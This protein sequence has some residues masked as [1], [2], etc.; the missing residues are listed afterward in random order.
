[1]SEYRNPTGEPDFSTLEVSRRG[2]FSTLE[3]K[4]T[5]GI[6]PSNAPASTSQN[7]PEQLS[8]YKTKNPWWRRYWLL[9]VVVSLLES[10]VTHNVEENSTTYESTITTPS[11][12]SST[13]SATSTTTSYPTV[14]P[15]ATPDPTDVPD[16]PIWIGTS[17]E[18]GEKYHIGFALDGT[19]NASC[20]YGVIPVPEPDNPCS[21][22]FLLP[23]GFQ[24]S[25]EGCGGVP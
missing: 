16:D 20:N 5:E 25:W 14:K 11:L 6:E 2:D 8:H 15:T 9:I 12:G 4:P 22:P 13:T 21:H 24:Y 19:K 3:V 23:N 17:E 1:M 7:P 10:N 18:D